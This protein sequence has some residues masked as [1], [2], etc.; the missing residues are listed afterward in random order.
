MPDSMLA[1]SDIILQLLPVELPPF[2]ILEH[3]RLVYDHM[4]RCYPAVSTPYKQICG[5]ETKTC[6]EMSKRYEFIPRF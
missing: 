2:G 1:L 5:K 3:R 4:K 6:V